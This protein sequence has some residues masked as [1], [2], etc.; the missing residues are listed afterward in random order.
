MFKFLV[1]LIV[2]GGIFFAWH[3]LDVFKA[4]ASCTVPIAYS[5]G[6]FD[7]RFDLSQKDFLLA[8]A[9][10]ES[11]WERAIGKNLFAYD[12][13]K[14]DL[15]INL[16][17]DYRQA[18]TE[19]LSQIET[20]VKSDENSYR[21]LEQQYRTLKSQ[22]NG[23]KSVYDQAVANFDAHSADYEAQVEAWNRGSRS[24]KKDFQAL[25]NARLSLATE[26]ARLKDLEARL[27]ALV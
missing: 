3:G 21:A 12:A 20:V 16:V 17:F 9:E 24:S 6:T 5:I 19:E 10:A 27:N 8:L 25:E 14:G 13:E 22:Y 4:P 26:L 11:V 1:T 15:E 23:L 18:V 2:L 7:R